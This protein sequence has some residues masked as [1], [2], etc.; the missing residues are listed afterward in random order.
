MYLER[1]SVFDY[2]NNKYYKPNGTFNTRSATDAIQIP[3]CTMFAFL[4]MHEVCELEKRVNDW[5]RASGG[6]GNAKEW[7]SST[8]LPKGAELRTGAIAVFDGT[9]G[10]VAGVVRKIDDT[11]GLLVESNYSANKSLRDWH[12]FNK[13]PSVELIVGK[14]PLVGCG[15]L[16]GFIYLPIND[17]RVARDTSKEQIEVTMEMVN[18]RVKPDGELFAKG[19]YCPMGVYNI[20]SKKTVGEYIW[21][22]LDDN[23]WIRDGEWVTYYKKSSDDELSQ[24]KADM[25]TIKKVADKYE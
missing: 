23:C 2:D 8:T 18:V 7:Y 12:F 17:I 11:H 24:I 21:Y 16:L 25:R 10:H 5:I 20:K 9:C 13:R 1:L 15:A 19:L 22:E 6:F 4:W 3:N 14:A